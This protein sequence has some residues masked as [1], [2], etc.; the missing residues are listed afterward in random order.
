MSDEAP[1]PGPPQI[2]WLVFAED[3]WINAA[4]LILARNLGPGPG[5]KLDVA[6]LPGITFTL[7]GEAAE[8]LRAR[9]AEMTPGMPSTPGAVHKGK[10]ARGRRANDPPADAE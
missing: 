3:R 4:Y 8:T 6:L 9:L 10:V 1:A 2:P 5:D 7:E